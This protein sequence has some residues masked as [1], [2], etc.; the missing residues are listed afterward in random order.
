MKIKVSQLL[1]I[2]GIVGC[3]VTKNTQ[4]LHPFLGE[5]V[6]CSNF[7]IYKLSEDNKQYV[8]IKIDGSAVEWQESQAYAIGKADILSV[9]YRKF[10]SVIHQVL[11]N[12]IMP[13]RMPKRLV[14]EMAKEGEVEIIIS[15]EEREKASNYQGYKVTVV[16]KDVIFDSLLIDYLRIDN[17]Y[18]GWLPG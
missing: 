8:S 11:C 4:P 5:S 9:H 16:L 18:V 14:E 6:G 10:D 3:A 2:A 17:V 15:E 13:V 7:I 1:L 12:D